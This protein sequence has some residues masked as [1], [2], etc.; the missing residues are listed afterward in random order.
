MAYHIYNDKKIYFD[1]IGEGSPLLFLH[2]NSVSSRMFNYFIELYKD[3]YK[4]I[5]LDFIGHG[6]S[7]RLIEFSTDFWFNQSLQVI[8]FLEKQKFGKV[9]IIGTSG[10]ALVALNVG[11]ERPDLV[12]KIIADSFEGEVSLNSIAD[13]IEEERNQ[14]KLNEEAIGFWKYNH[15]DDWE[16]IVDKDTKVTIEHHRLIG[17]FFHHDLSKLEVPILLT[18]SL[19]DEYFREIKETYNLLNSKIKH[20]KI[21]LYSEGGHPALVTNAE[22][23]SLL[24]KEYLSK[25]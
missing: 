8:S 5:L 7:D 2:G 12:G 18:G 4:V 11:L 20:S 6:Q 14:A 1:I 9:D 17:K 13:G 25:G 23:F 19:K 22:A 15:G 16:S 3:D 24:V 21:H 10:G